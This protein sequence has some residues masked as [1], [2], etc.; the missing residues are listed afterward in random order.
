VAEAAVP[1]AVPVAAAGSL[2]AS[3]D[4]AYDPAAE[5]EAESEDVLVVDSSEDEEGTAFPR[6]PSQR[7]PR[8]P[9]LTAKPAATAAA[10][11]GT[12]GVD[13]FGEPE[14]EGK[15]TATLPAHFLA[16]PTPPAHLAASAPLASTAKAAA[17]VEEPAYR[18]AA[19]SS[20]L[21]PLSAAQT[22]PMWKYVR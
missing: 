10:E 15:K 13:V 20:K 17:A 11:G 3:E 18:W 9:A 6:P 14:K 21:R 2:S 5:E 16:A 19:L 12:D 22:A 4:S 7:A 1:A 8:P